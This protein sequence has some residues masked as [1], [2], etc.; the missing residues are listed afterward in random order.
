MEEIYA[1]VGGD[2]DVPR[3]VYLPNLGVLVKT[4]RVR[5]TKVKFLEYSGSISD[6][7][8]TKVC[9]E[10]RKILK[11][12]DKAKY[13]REDILKVKIKNHISKRKIFINITLRVYKEKMREITKTEKETKSPRRLRD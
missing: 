13:T 1:E 6:Q 8:N 11:Y 2:F 9:L 5:N 7:K 3:L 12:L 10:P 4:D